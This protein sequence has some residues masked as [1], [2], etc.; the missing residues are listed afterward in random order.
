M[1]AQCEKDLKRAKK[2]SKNAED[3]HL[4]EEAK[5]RLANRGENSDGPSR[6]RR[7]DASDDDDDDE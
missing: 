4:V 3:E 1:V 5:T 2:A 7:S 6:L